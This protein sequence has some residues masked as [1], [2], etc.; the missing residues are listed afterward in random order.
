MLKIYTI[1]LLAAVFVVC[2]TVFLGSIWSEKGRKQRLLKALNAERRDGESAG[3]K[4]M[5]ML[6]LN[7]VA[8]HGPESEEARAFRFGTDSPMMKHLHEDDVAL[9]L[10]N[11]RADTIDATYRRIKG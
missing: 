4:E 5:A 3:V 8:K 11:Q 10:F 1:L 9:D 6:Y 7:M 2:I